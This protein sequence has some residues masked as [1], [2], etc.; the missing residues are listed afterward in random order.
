MLK[1]QLWKGERRHNYQ[2]GR[3]EK[4]SAQDSM[5]DSLP[6]DLPNQRRVHLLKSNYGLSSS[7][8]DPIPTDLAGV[9]V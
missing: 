2:R 6:L 5:R 8:K 4:K 1:R 7:R 3:V 9:F